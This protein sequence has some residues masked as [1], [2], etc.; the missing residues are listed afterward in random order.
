[1][2]RWMIGGDQLVEEQNHFIYEIAKK[3]IEFG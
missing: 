2:S 1:M 3:R